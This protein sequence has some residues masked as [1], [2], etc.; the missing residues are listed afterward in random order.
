MD[1]I[2]YYIVYIGIMGPFYVQ[3]SKIWVG[4]K[5][6]RL[7]LSAL[8]LYSIIFWELILRPRWLQR[9]QRHGWIS[10]LLLQ[11]LS[12]WASNMRKSK[13]TG[14]WNPCRNYFKSCRPDL[15]IGTVVRVSAKPE[16]R[17]KHAATRLVFLAQFY[18]VIRRDVV[19]SSYSKNHRFKYS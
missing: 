9:R 17:W 1:H 3:F 13:Q 14:F 12:T 18:M 2:L 19:I 16:N 8:K 7:I 10:I 6:I 5:C 11:L 4:S 15:F